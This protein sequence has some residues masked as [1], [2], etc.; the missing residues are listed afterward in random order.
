MTTVIIQPNGD[1]TTLYQEVLNLAALGDQQIERASQV[2][3]DAQGRWW[4]QILDGPLLGPFSL[5]SEALA[6]EVDWLITHR[7]IPS[8]A[9]ATRLSPQG[10]TVGPALRDTGHFL[11]CLAQ[12]RAVARRFR[13]LAFKKELLHDTIATP[14]G[15]G[16]IDRRRH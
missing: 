2:E 7:L 16:P 1:I 13:F 11:H 9:D 3:P 6:A 8:E 5:R 10:H 12:H 4:A 14:P 15:R